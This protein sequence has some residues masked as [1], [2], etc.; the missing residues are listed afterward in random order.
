MRR[1]VSGLGKLN[2]AI[3]TYPI[4]VLCATAIALPAQTFSTLHTF[5]G[6]DG[7]HPIAGLV[8]ATNG[9]LYGTT[10]EGGVNNW[11]A[12]FRITPGGK[13]MTLYSFCSESDC[14]DGAYPYAGLVQ[15]INGN[16]YG[17]TSGGGTNSCAPSSGC[18]TVFKITRGR[19]RPP[20]PPFF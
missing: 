15:A 10:Q 11:G 20:E 4:L 3:R 17:T 9:G 1:I 2:W 19:L 14:R 5:D 7:A 8:Q 12:I 6:T 13:L 18:G 16:F